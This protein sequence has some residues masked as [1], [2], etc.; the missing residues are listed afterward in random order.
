MQ[1]EP[2]Q[3]L[4]RWNT[5]RSK[6]ECDL[7]LSPES[8]ADY[9]S[10]P[11]SE[12]VRARILESLIQLANYRNDSPGFISTKP[13]KVGDMATCEGLEAFLTP[14]VEGALSFSKFLDY[15]EEK[16]GDVT[17]FVK[18]I[19]KDIAGLLDNWQADIF[20][21]EPYANVKKIQANVEPLFKEDFKQ[22]NITEAAALACRVLIHLLTLKLNRTD[23]DR[24]QREIGD[25]LVED[26]LFDSLNKAIDFLIRAFQKGD[27]PTEEQQIVNAK[28]GTHV[29]SGWS[30]TDRPNLPPM[31]F[32]TAAAVDA[33]AELDLYLIRT[34]LKREW[35]ADGLKLAVFHK[36]NAEKLLH[37]QLC[38][39][40]ARRWVQKA[41]LLNLIDGYGQYAERLPQGNDPI[42]EE[43][44]FEKSPEGYEQ[45]QE[46]L[47]RWKALRHPPMVFY[48]SLYALLIL[49]WSWGDRTDD[50]EF[51]D[52]D[53][54]NKINRAISQLVYNYSSIPLV[55]EI[56]NRF[57]YVFALP[58]KGIFKPGSE[59]DRGYLD[60]AFLPLL[61]RL[62]VLFVV[63]GV[64]DRNMLEP[65]IRN[66]YVELLQSRHRDK[67]EYSALW[68]T[69]EIEVFSTQRAIQALTFYYA[70]AGGKEIV[71][72]KSGGGGI[73]LRNKTGLPL[74]LEAL[75]ERP[76]EMPEVVPTPAAGASLETPPQ[77]ETITDDKFSDYCKNID[78]WR[79]SRVLPSG[80]AE[81]LQG[82]AKALGETVIADYKAGKVRDVVAAKLILNSLASIFAAPESDDGTARESEL[83]LLSTQYRDLSARSASDSAGSTHE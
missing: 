73:I 75:F 1:I 25:D 64:G 53:A 26:R 57:E 32:F 39:D 17:S 15:Y 16:G 77:V 5:I 3:I 58:G 79:P 66:L 60:S 52:D 37:F 40:M 59:K 22:I 28:V 45:Y 34:V 72:E 20:S 36:Q 68:S 21:G 27:G 71:E 29:G 12:L 11:E 7:S 74:V 9:L 80:V 38:V 65:V 6:E 4:N 49:L 13:E 24:F 43:L 30:W 2:N 19:K 33:F 63:Y 23:E 14:A 70:Y 78:G 55:K 8:V 81:V 61:T 56:L 31:L 82:K 51:V 50:G 62:L 18:A 69:K 48:N 35:V 76:V 46:D 47:E 10:I 42:G 67:I 83:S 54:K 41:V 44:Y